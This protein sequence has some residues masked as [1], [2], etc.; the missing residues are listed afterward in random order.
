MGSTSV[1]NQPVALSMLPIA[2]YGSWCERPWSLSE[3]AD[4]PEVEV[5][6]AGAVV[7]PPMMLSVDVAVMAVTPVDCK[8]AVELRDVIEAELE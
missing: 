3:E 7:V 4:E 2:Q 1:K 8:D 6:G 5:V